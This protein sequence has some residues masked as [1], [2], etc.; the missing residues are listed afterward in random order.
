MQSWGTRSV[1]DDRDTERFPSKSGVIGLLCAALG[2]PR[3][4]PLD[5]LTALS[6]A[7]RADRPGRVERDFQT[8]RDVPTSRA[9]PDGSSPTPSRTVVSWRHYLADAVFLV[10]IEGDVDQLEVLHEALYC[11]HWPPSLGRKSYVP[12]APVFLPD[13]LRPGHL[14]AEMRAYR[15]VV[16]GQQPPPDALEVEWECAPA[17]L[18]KDVT[19]AEP[20]Q[21]VPVSFEHGRR[22]HRVRW[23]QREWIPLPDPNRG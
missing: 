1:F 11:P 3:E 13:G 4:V 20:R 10:G 15:W 22:E 8:A 7:A 21:D 6:M 9:L 14:D 16:D 18:L 17:T 12:G 23:V 2:R 5:D 19:R